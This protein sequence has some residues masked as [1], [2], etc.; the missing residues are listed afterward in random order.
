LN[1]LNLKE[2]KIL[3]FLQSL[4]YPFFLLAG[5]LLLDEEICKIVHKP[6]SQ[7]LQTKNCL[8]N[9]KFMVLRNQCSGK[10]YS[11]CTYKRNKGIFVLSG[12]QI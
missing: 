3:R 7:P 11:L 5:A 8:Q 12:L 4:S 6:S 2:F 1:F 9:T 10:E